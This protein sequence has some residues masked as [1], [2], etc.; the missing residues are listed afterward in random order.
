M[1]VTNFGFRENWV[2]RKVAGMKTTIFSIFDPTWTHILVPPCPNKE[3][4]KEHFFKKD[5]NYIII[6]FDFKTVN[7]N[8]FAFQFLHS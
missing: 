8:I 1:A 3:F 6:N 5:R 2:D 4:V 7:T